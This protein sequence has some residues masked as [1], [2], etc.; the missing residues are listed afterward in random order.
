LND[1]DDWNFVGLLLC[2]L[3]I[4]LSNQS[5]QFVEVEGWAIIVITIQVEVSHTNFTEI[6]RMVFIVID[7]VMVHA[8]SITATTGMFTVFA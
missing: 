3:V 7:S 8:T 2:T 1:I 6:S 5:P 4:I